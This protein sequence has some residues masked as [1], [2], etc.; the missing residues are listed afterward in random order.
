[1]VRICFIIHRSVGLLQ[2]ILINYLML[3]LTPIAFLKE[4]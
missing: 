2:V 1:M 3:M 4:K